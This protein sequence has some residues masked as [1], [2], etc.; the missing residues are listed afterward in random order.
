[1][2]RLNESTCGD[3]SQPEANNVR[4]DRCGIDVDFRVGSDHSRKSC[5]AGMDLTQTAAMMIERIKGSRGDDPSLTEA[6]AKLLFE[7]S[8]PSD[9]RFRASKAGPYRRPESSSET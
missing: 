8:C 3:V 7:P 1:M 2:S 6:T 4:L 9:E 5:G